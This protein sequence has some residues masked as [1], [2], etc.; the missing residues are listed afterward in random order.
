[1]KRFIPLV[2]L[3][4][5]ATSCQRAQNNSTSNIDIQQPS[6]HQNGNPSI[7]LTGKN[8]L[9]RFPTP[10]GYTRTVEPEGSF[11]HYL[12]TLDLKP[13]G[14]KVKYFDGRT[15][16]SN[17]VYIAVVDLEIGT[18]DLHQCADAV[19]RLRGEYLWN[20]ER[21]DEIK[22]NFT[23]GFNVEYKE[24]MKGRRMVVDGNRTYWDNQNNAS[25][26]YED[27]WK[28]L[29]LIFAYAG[30]ASLEK[31]TIN[32]PINEANIGDI[33]IQGGFP[34]HAIIIVDQ[35]TNSEGKSI[36]LLAQSYMP[37]QE[38]QILMNP[39]NDSQNPWY[40]LK[41]GV[42]ETPEWTFSS[43]DFRSF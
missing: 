3:L 2:T 21:Y 17:D 7:I 11:Q 22:F 15:K 34:G 42:I 20:Q 35:A 1:M 43:N 41:E 28:Y 13:H 10:Q 37:A 25:N 32:K 9:E 29:E 24:W 23:N 27:F 19:M 36:F 38:L 14:S 8:V 33:L 26:T 31:E 12:R 16:E 40:E 30:T 6:N 39:N 4:I 18:K 5:I